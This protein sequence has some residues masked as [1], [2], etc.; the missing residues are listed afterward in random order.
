MNLT[1]PL[2]KPQSL[3]GN[4]LEIVV[5][6]D[7]AVGLATFVDTSR[8]LLG[9]QFKSICQQPD[10]AQKKLAEVDGHAQVVET[11]TINCR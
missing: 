8:M 10:L 9:E 5:T 3:Q 2:T 7:S 11:M 4:T 6:D 1:L